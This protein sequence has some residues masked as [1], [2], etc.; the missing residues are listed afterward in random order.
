MEKRYQV[1]FFDK[2]DTLQDVSDD[3]ETRGEAV[4]VA[5]EAVLTGNPAAYI[6]V[7]EVTDRPLFRV[8]PQTRAKWTKL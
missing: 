8:E 5:R 3:F 2:D 7:H 4:D 1:H 6:E